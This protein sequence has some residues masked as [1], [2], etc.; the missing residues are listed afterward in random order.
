MNERKLKVYVDGKL[1]DG[2][3]TNATYRQGERLGLEVIRKGKIEKVN[4]MVHS[5][6]EDL[7]TIKLIGIS[8]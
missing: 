6:E 1:V 8:Y 4:F 5:I 2:F 3:K 7:N